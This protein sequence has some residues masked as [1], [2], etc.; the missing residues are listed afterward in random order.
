MSPEAV[1]RETLPTL[2]VAVECLSKAAEKE[3]FLKELRTAI[4]EAFGRVVA[5][6]SRNYDPIYRL[7]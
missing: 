1:V 3:A 2:N 5:V 7:S 4:E 6:G